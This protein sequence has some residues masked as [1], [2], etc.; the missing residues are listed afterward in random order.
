VPRLFAAS[1]WI[2]STITYSTVRSF[3]LNFGELSK[4]ASVSGVVLRT[5]G[6]SESIACRSAFEVSPCRI[7]CLTPG[8]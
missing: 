1:E 8:S 7:A 2:S 6:V 3:S 4:I 5:W